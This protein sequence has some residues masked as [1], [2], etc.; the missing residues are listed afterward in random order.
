[1]GA[2]PFDA[3]HCPT[4]Q[5]YCTPKINSLGC[6]PEA[7][8]YGVPSYSGPDNFSIRADFV[9]NNKTGILLWGG[10]SANTPFF[11]GTLCIAPPIVR[12]PPMQSGGNAGVEDCS[13]AYAFSFSQAYA[14]SQ[15][16]S[17]GATV[18]AQ[19]WSRDPGFPAPENV[20]LTNGVRFTLLP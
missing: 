7:Y 17:P 10:A 11:G 2:F 18:F 9:L 20:G 1:M 3:E 6:V 14:A 8:S 16:L 12:T 19:F 15:F 13:G 5:P 4:C